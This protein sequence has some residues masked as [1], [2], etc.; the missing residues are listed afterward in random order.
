MYKLV[1]YFHSPLYK[2]ALSKYYEITIKRDWGVDYKLD[3][4]NYAKIAFG[5]SELEKNKRESF[6][7]IYEAL[8]KWWGVF[9]NA[10]KGHWSSDEIYSALK[11]YCIEYSRFNSIKL[12]S[13]NLPE[14]TKGLVEALIQLKDLK[15]SSDYPWMP[16]AKFTHF[17][18]PKL[19]P[20][21]DNEVIWK[22]VMNGVFKFDYKQWCKQ[23]AVNPNGPGVYFSVNYILWAGEIIRQADDGFMNYF[24][25]WFKSAIGRHRDPQ[26]VLSD[27]GEY[28]A[29]AFEFVAI[30]AANL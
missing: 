11:K 25:D 5:S 12:I 19:F 16:V 27:I 21:Y 20:I 9:R 22:Q 7:K 28:Y 18:N 29:T 6:Y 14:E 26:N 3:L 1:D 8:K 2:Q 4:Y 23:N 30:G 17:Y 15:P 10:K 13:N 24:S